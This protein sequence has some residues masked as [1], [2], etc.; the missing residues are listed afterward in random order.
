MRPDERE[1]AMGRLF[2]G[3]RRV[4]RATAKAAQS[5]SVVEKRRVGPRLPPGPCLA[6]SV[7]RFRVF[8]SFAVARH[9]CTLVK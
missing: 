5:K 4:E 3:W 2:Y 9:F 6:G 8:V 1:A 7:M